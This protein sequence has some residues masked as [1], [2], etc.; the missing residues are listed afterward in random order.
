MSELRTIRLLLEMLD[1]VLRWR[2]VGL[3]ALAAAAV[4]LEVMSAFGVMWLIGLLHDPSLVWKLPFIGGLAQALCCD[5][6]RILLWLCFGVAG[7]YALKNLF[8]LAQTY[9][10]LWVPYQASIQIS[11][12]LL[13]YYL[14]MPYANHFQRNSAELVRNVMTSV[15]VVFRMVMIALVGI[16]S[17][18]LIVGGLVI[19]LLLASSIETLFAVGSLGALV[20]VMLRATQKALGRWGEEVQE[21]S[22][23]VLKHVTQSL[24]GVK[25]VQVRGR[26]QYFVSRYLG[27]RNALT[28]V[29]LHKETVASMPRLI[30]ETAL[31]VVL[32]LLIAL[33][34]M[35]KEYRGE[36][37]PLLGLYAYAGFRLMPAVGRIAVNLQNVR[38]GA[39]AVVDLHRDM[40]AFGLLGAHGSREGR[41]EVE[42]EIRIERLS[43]TY[44]GAEAPALRDIEIAIR[45]GETIGIAG[46]TGSG[47]STLVDVLLGLLEPTAGRVT[48]D[49]RDVRSDLRAWQRAIGYVPQS[50]FLLDDTLR[51]NVAFGIGDEAIDEEAVIEAASL[52]QLDEVYQGRPE[53]LDLEVGERGVRLSGG[54]RQ[55]IAIARALYGRPSVLV[56]DEATSALDNTTEKLVSQA[57]HGLGGTRTLVIVAHRLS[58][59]KACDRVVFMKDGRIAGCGSYEQ[60]VGLLPEF[61]AMAAADRSAVGEVA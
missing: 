15:D 41:T 13:E 16:L 45:R 55:R 42:G 47:K 35:R 24:N 22:T 56:L 52:A 25:D 29:L 3:V 50:P 23:A 12:R 46:P 31:V 61:A 59:I 27:E 17:D 28:R 1:P 51:R 14:A 53:G 49:G 58:T 57:I 11:G 36:L 10:Q 38:F 4:V 33:A 19:V 54:Q 40:A 43:Y 32:V 20:L 2:C 44:P 37:V 9:C 34:V 5:N 48:V 8:L 39:P 30:L 6:D 18:V 21:R 7:F 26:E 60:L